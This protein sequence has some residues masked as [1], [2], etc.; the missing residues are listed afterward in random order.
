MGCLLRIKF[1]VLQTRM[2]S[3]SKYIFVG[4]QEETGER[5]QY[6]QQEEETW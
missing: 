3:G 2:H 1:D 4:S 5:C 6:K